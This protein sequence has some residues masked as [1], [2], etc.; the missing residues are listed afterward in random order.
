[1]PLGIKVL[2]PLGT[3]YRGGFKLDRAALQVAK[4][5][6]HPALW[7]WYIA[8]EPDLWRRPPSVIREMEEDLKAL[9]TS[10]PTCITLYQGHE[11][12]IYGG[13]TDT[14]STILLLF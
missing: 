6:R 2:G 1:M 5:D 7:G 9:E 14:Q 13:I 8:D 4:F 11:A 10:K 12:A 3:G